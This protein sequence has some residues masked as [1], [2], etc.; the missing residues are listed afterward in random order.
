MLLN[1]QREDHKIELEIR[2]DVYHLLEDDLEE[3]KNDNSKLQQARIIKLTDI[4]LTEVIGKGAFGE[5]FKGRW[6]GI[7]VA[8]KK[9]FP[10]NMEKFGFPFRSISPSTASSHS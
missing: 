3:T 7:D 1:N 2:D 10:E 4:K 5:V 9:M 8:V 6:R